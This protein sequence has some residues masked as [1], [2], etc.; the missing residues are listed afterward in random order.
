[1]GA[2]PD[3]GVVMP[4][5]IHQIVPAFGAGARVVGNLI[6]G[7]AGIGADSLRKIV[8]IARQVFVRHDELAGPVQAEERS[9]RFDG[10]LIEGEMLGRLRDRALELGRPSSRRLSWSRVDQVERVAVKY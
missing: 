7:Q 10:Q 4:A 3:P 8:E 2:G 1:M 9:V 6:G 5:P